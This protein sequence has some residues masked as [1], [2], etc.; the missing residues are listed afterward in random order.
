[1]ASTEG[2]YMKSVE[3]ERRVDPRL[4]WLGIICILAGLMLIL[5]GFF[6]SDPASSYHNKFLSYLCTNLGGLLVFGASYTLISE[7]FLRREFA[8]EMR[9]AIDDRFRQSRINHTIIDSGLVKILPSFSHYELHDRVERAQ[10]VRMIVIKNYIYFREYREPLRER[11]REGQLNLEVLMPDPRDRDGVAVT[12]RRYE[13]FNG[14]GLAASIAGC[15]DV[16]LKER[17]FDELPDD[18]KGR[19]S[20]HL[21]R[22]NPLYSAY[23]FD[24]EELW[25]IPYHCR[26][27][28]HAIPVF[29]YRGI[30]ESLPIYRDVLDLFRTATKHDLAVPL[31]TRDE[32]ERKFAENE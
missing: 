5:V 6:V 21:S 9:R 13:E 30:D 3:S 17:I 19:L 26:M 23:L 25:Y 1:M 31:G 4:F 27:G 12:A 14:V 24:R 28:R 7:A 10:S 29:V 20:L 2:S 11:I 18:S 8:K 22:Q 16:W 15:V 32:S